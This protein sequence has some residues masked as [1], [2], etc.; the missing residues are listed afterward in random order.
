MNG[1]PLLL[2][3]HEKEETEEEIGEGGLIKTCHLCGKAQ[4]GQRRGRVRCAY[5]KRVFCLQQLYKKFKMRADPNDKAFKCPRCLG[6]CCC[7]TDCQKPPPHVHCK[8]YKVRQNKRRIRE[9]AHQADAS[10]LDNGNRVEGTIEKPEI[11]TSPFTY[12]PDNATTLFPLPPVENHGIAYPENVLTTTFYYSTDTPKNTSL[13][14]H[15]DWLTQLN[16]KILEDGGNGE[17]DGGEA[18]SH[19]GNQFVENLRYYIQNRANM[20]SS[21]L[22]LL[23]SQLLAD[24][25]QLQSRAEK[26][27][28]VFRMVDSFN[29]N[30]L[31]VT[32]TWNLRN[33]SLGGNLR[34]DSQ[35]DS[36]QEVHD[37]PALFTIVNCC[38]TVLFSLDVNT[39]Y[40]EH[41]AISSL[42]RRFPTRASQASPFSTREL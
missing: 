37:I 14:Q 10:L 1:P 33:S 2:S 12:Y 23:Q 6:I 25:N 9:R 11:E 31:H 4:C 17:N 28:I 26:S 16:L 39:S 21:E 32:V 30:A 20:S 8:V 19:G 29:R 35:L 7:V 36:C 18:H 40:N 38:P 27:D 42:S 22:S 5:C 15:S 41:N 3:N 24:A 13:V 34:F